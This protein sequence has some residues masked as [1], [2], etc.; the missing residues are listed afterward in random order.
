MTFRTT[1]V[2]VDDVLLGKVQRALGT[3]TLKAT[4]EEAFLDVLRVRARRAEVAAL[5]TMEDMDLADPEV[6][7]AAWRS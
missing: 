2:A 7:S 6:M 3:R 1:S 4:I 5:A